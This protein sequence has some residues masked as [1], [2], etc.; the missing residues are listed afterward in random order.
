MRHRG[1]EVHDCFPVEMSGFPSMPL[2]DS[3]CLHHSDSSHKTQSECQ[4]A[5]VKKAEHHINDKHSQLLKLQGKS[6]S[7][8]ERKQ[9]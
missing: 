9:K 3:V 2:G 7:M 4:M 6:Y 5:L 1:R 8:R